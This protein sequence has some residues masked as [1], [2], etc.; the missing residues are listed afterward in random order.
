MNKITI[1][2]VLLVLIIV[3]F[4]IYNR[5]AVNNQEIKNKGAATLKDATYLI[6]GKPVTL[7]NGLSEIEIM[8]SVASKI[9]TRYFGN[10]AKGDFNGDGREDVAFILT[11]EPG[12]SAVFYY[13]VVALNT[14]AGYVGSD[15]VL[16]GDRIAPQTIG[17]DNGVTATGTNRQNVIV[18]NYATRLP[19]EPFTAKPSVG[20]SLWLKLDP[21]TMRLGEVA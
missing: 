21:A 20:K 18:V 19:N 5:P 4:S 10:E 3:G 1:A 8:P 17:I 14:P 13:V 12:G 6:E 15:G 9:I 16:L 2:I 7:V 11:Q